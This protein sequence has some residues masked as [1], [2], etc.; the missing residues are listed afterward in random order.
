MIR[1]AI[2]DDHAVVR[3]GLKYAVMLAKD[4]ELA[5]ELE[6]GKGAA[7]AVVMEK[8][9]VILLDIRMPD[10]DGL[11]ALESI[12]SVKSSAKVIILS[13]SEAE[14]DIY[15]AVKLGAKGYVVKDRD[16]SEILNAIR[17][18]AEGGE[19]FPEAVKETFRQRQQMPD[20]TPR[21][22]EVLGMVS[23]GLSNQE[24]GTRLG[25]GAETAKI[26]IK[27]IF[28]KMGVANRAEC[29]AEAIR[30]GLMRV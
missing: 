29:V 11:S 17:I 24:I 23:K 30:R 12:L 22:F 1:V 27:H 7:A 15:R 10:V 16:S 20:L 26:H 5:F 9:D 8:P 3:M 6:D 28:D 4:M 14:E 2:I 13:T 19:Y 21:E 25:V 18:V